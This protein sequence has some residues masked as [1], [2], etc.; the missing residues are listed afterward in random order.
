MTRSRFPEAPTHSNHTTAETSNGAADDP[1]P[2][3]TLLVRGSKLIIRP[4][5]RADSGSST[6]R[7]FDEVDIIFAQA[8]TS[9]AKKMKK[10]QRELIPEV[11]IDITPKM[12]KVMSF[13]RPSRDMPLLWGSNDK[14][15]WTTILI[16]HTF[17]PKLVSQSSMRDSTIV[18][19]VHLAG[20]RLLRISSMVNC[21]ISVTPRTRTPS[22]SHGTIRSDLILRW[23]IYWIISPGMTTKTY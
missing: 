4:P 1:S 18:H 20:F 16:A 10:T 21:P 22:E 2:S 23:K 15:K 3:Y 19:T 5:H 13:A 9:P 11:Y 14:G 6:K 12:R 17:S 7:K 8:P